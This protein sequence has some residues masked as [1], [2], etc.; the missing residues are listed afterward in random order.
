MIRVD[1]AAN[2]VRRASMPGARRSRHRLPAG[3]A[4]VTWPRRRPS[5]TALLEMLT[6]VAFADAAPPLWNVA[7][8]RW[9]RHRADRPRA[10]MACTAA[11]ETRSTSLRT[12]ARDT[13]RKRTRTRATIER[14][15]AEELEHKEPRSARR[16]AAARL[17][18][19]SFLIRA[20]C[21]APSRFPS[22]SREIEHVGPHRHC[23]SRP[24]FGPPPRA[25][26]AARTAGG[27]V[28]RRPL[29]AKLERR[30]RRLRPP[31]GVRPL[32]HPSPC[33]NPPPPTSSP[34]PTACTR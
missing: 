21:R 29:P 1:H 8:S 26:R 6:S 33:A 23:R 30:D 34:R 2:S 3:R 14:I 4:V 20:G 32:P 25:R 31:A 9:A 12:A 19:M 5:I 24:A 22:A 17:P 27:G 18:L 7:G 28:R 11:V 16:G 10:A 15:Q 13:G